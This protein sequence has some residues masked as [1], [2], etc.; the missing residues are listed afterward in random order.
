MMNTNY[1]SNASAATVISFYNGSVLS[2]S[3]RTDPSTGQVWSITDHGT[4][5]S[6]DSL[7]DFYN[8]GRN[9]E[10]YEGL[11]KKYYNP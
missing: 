2:H 4:V 3:V 8:D 11:T 1:V 5:R 7:Q 9:R 10:I 6:Y